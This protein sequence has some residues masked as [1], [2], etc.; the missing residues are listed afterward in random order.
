MFSFSSIVQLSA[1]FP[2]W[3]FHCFVAGVVFAEDCAA[4]GFHAEPHLFGHVASSNAGLRPLGQSGFCAQRSPL[5]VAFS[6]NTLRSIWDL[7]TYLD[8]VVVVCD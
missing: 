3:A 6:R 5:T 2:G 4:L 7:Y 1:R 8:D